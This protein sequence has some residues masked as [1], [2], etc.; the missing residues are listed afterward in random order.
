LLISVLLHNLVVKLLQLLLGRL[1]GHILLLFNLFYLLGHLL[2]QLLL[3]QILEHAWLGEV[4]KTREV[5]LSL[6][7]R[8][9]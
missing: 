3:Y 5:L 4:T 1:L 2:L 7:D 6:V 9:G 8:F